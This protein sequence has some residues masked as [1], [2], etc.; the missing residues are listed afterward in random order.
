MAIARIENGQVVEIRHDLTLTDVP[1]HKRAMWR[2]VGDDIRPNYN[3]ATQ[4][5]VQ[6]YTIEPDQVVPLYVAEDRF[7][8][9]GTKAVLLEAVDADAETVRQSFLT[10]GTGMAM[11]YREKFEQA[12]A[13]EDLGEAN[14]NALSEADAKVQFPTLAASLG[15]EAE[16][17]WD[18]AQLVIAKYEAWAAVSFEIERARLSAKKSISDASDAAA[19]RAAYEAITWPKN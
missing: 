13:V 16:T 2:P 3:G 9:E 8:L 17:L 14:A 10:A 4:R 5:L 12:Q 15:V 18:C 7:D 1:E 6:S 19:A 11:T